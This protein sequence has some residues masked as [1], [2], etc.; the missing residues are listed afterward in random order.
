MNFFFFVFFFFVCF[1]DFVVLLLLLVW[2]DELTFLG[3]LDFVGVDRLVRGT[4]V[5]AVVDDDA[6]NFLVDR[7][8]GNNVVVMNSLDVG[9]KS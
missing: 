1:F 8:R 6:Y 3:D 2:A 9:E 7:Y 5:V 4:F